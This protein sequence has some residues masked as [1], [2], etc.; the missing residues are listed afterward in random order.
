MEALLSVFVN[1]TF[2]NPIE[3]DGLAEVLNDRFF[4]NPTNYSP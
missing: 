4:I 3:I 1:A 2:G